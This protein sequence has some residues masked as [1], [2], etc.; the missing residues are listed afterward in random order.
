MTTE[1]KVPALGESVSEATVASWLKKPGD[2]VQMDETLVEL[3][4]DKVTLE[5]NA[6][7]SGVLG[8][9]SAAEG[10]IVKMGD[11][12]GVIE[13]GAGSASSASVQ[14]KKETVPKTET[15]SEPSSAPA[16][17]PKKNSA[18]DKL[19]PSVA[20]LASEQNIAVEQV[21][22]TGKDGRVLKGDLL[23][24]SARGSA[25]G[26]SSH[27]SAA[28]APQIALDLS[29]VAPAPQRGITPQDT[30]REERIKMTRLRKTIATRLK[31][32][33]NTAARK[34]R[35]LM[36][37]LRGTIWFIKIT[38]ILA[39]RFQRQTALWYLLSEMPTD[40]GFRML[41]KPLPTLESERVTAS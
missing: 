14:E 15:A 38:M 21:Q 25:G 8:D 40:S 19:A 39:L 30:P 11:L 36:R 27:T 20:K 34:S 5:V 23:S 9:Y 10:E 26:S 37:K 16:S 6:P 12:L 4:T 41:K 18:H 35:P 2:A 17:A 28:N 33:Q 7:V 1:I 24:F 31:E 13:E 3:E 22:G 32:A 29:A